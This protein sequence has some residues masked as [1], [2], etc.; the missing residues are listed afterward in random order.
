MEI[1]VNHERKLVEV[2][3]THA[4]K[5][6]PAVRERLKP[7]YAKYKQQRYLV[8]VFESG[9]RDLYQ[10]TRDLLAFNKR[11][12]AELAVQ[13]QKKRSAASLER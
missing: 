11:R 3:L 4:E 6:D 9:D 5:N 10:S 8:A 13:R 2:W 7:L 1:N 12:T